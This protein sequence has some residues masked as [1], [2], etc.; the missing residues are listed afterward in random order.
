MDGSQQT[1][2]AAPISLA[3]GP[4]IIN[5]VAASSESDVHN[6][7]GLPLPHSCAMQCRQSTSRHVIDYVHCK[8]APKSPG[9]LASATC[10]SSAALI[11]TLA[12]PAVSFPRSIFYSI[13]VYQNKKKSPV[14]AVDI[15]NLSGKKQP[16]MDFLQV[17]PNSIAVN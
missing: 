4:K 13:S 1:K 14:Q 8:Q 5:L 10:I 7:A 16:A 3:F 6:F 12:S 2:R 9:S 17:R 15:L 11:A